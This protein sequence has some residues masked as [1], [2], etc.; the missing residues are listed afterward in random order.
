MNN[1]FGANP[2]LL[3]IKG[4]EV[5]EEAKRFRENVEKVF[6][7][8][9]EMVNSSYL[10]P[11]AVAIAN[12]IQSY[13]DDLNNMTKIIENYGQYCLNASSKVI[14]NQEEIISSIN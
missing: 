1:T 11:E 8:V 9:N 13:R 2:E 14:K 5:L 10:S 6:K 3:R 4:N 12:E 7:T